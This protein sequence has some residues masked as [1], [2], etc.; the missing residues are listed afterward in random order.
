MKPIFFRSAFLLSGAL[1]QV[2][3]VNTMFSSLVI[4]PPILLAGVIATT[5][6]R[7]FSSSWQW[8]VVAGVLL[9][10]LTLGRIGM[11]ALEYVL[12]AALL[13][14]TAKELVLSYHMGRV[15]FFG[16]LL[17]MFETGVHFA[18]VTFFSL[19]SDQ[20]VPLSS[21]F[22]QVHWTIFFASLPVSVAV[23]ALLFPLTFS[24]E[25]YL[26]LFERTKVGR[27]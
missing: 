23:C 5:L 7:G 11:T 1:L 8:A 25:R 19:V 6:F 27:R 2:S 3:L 4:A 21:F 12:A 24:F 9:D 16:G 10:S 15:L 26:D 14:F 22:A 13:S 17:W 20:A 18:E